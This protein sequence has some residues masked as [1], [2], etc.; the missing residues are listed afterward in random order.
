MADGVYSR[1]RDAKIKQNELIQRRIAAENACEILGADSVSFGDL[2][3]NQLD[4]IALLDVVQ[5]VE[6]IISKYKPDTI[7]THHAG[8][9]NIDHRLTHEAVITACRPQADNTVKTLLFYE[10]PSSTEWQ[11]PYTSHVFIPNWFIDISD[12]LTLKIKAL[13]E[14]HNELRKWPHPRSIEGVEYLARWRGATICV[15][16]AEAFMLGRKLS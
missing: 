3:D 16:A 6:K 2:P 10:I 14:Y 15:E 5:E 9:L 13:E 12:E 11:A 8:D 4:T 7:F 1:E